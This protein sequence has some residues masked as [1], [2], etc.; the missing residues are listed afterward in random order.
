MR[1]SKIAA[2]VETRRKKESPERPGHPAGGEALPAW[3]F[4]YPILLFS[5]VSSVESVESAIAF[6]WDLIP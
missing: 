5:S 6:L 2:G 1:K 3:P 4:P